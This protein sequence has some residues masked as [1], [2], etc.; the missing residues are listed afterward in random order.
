MEVLD[1]NE[2]I[3]NSNAIFETYKKMHLEK[4]QSLDSS[5]IN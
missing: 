3:K 5:P 2:T 4:S 1:K